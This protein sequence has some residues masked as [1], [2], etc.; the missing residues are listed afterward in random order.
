MG[1]GAD[2]YGVEGVARPELVAAL[3]NLP[4]P[5]ANP[6][7]LASLIDGHAGIDIDLGLIG[8]EAVRRSA[9]S[10]AFPIL[11]RL[12]ADVRKLQDISDEHP[13]LDLLETVLTDLL[14]NQGTKAASSAPV[15]RLMEALEVID[16]APLVENLAAFASKPVSDQA[17]G[18]IVLA[19][20]VYFSRIGQSFTGEPRRANTD[21]GPAYIVKSE[22]ALLTAEI[23]KELGAN[24]SNKSLATHMKKANAALAANLPAAES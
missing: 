8:V 19:V 2:F 9:R 18:R 14:A 22:Q 10:A 3:S 13:S 24:V 16:H 20:A 6:A 11:R 1:D 5:P 4:H 7:L 15:P 21:A 12:R 23:L 17:V